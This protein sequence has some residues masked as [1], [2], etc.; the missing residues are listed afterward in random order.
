MPEGRLQCRRGMS[1][2]SRPNGLEKKK[3]DRRRCASG[4]DLEQSD[5]KQVLEG[6]RESAIGE[7]GKS[8]C[9]GTRIR[10]LQAAGGATPPTVWQ[11]R[12]P[13]V[14]EDCK[15]VAPEPFL[16]QHNLIGLT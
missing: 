15:T 13:D 4:H 11:L 5:I 16:Q 3:H 9:M 12:V 7:N 1:Y 2:R 10:I 6:L 14:R 8:R